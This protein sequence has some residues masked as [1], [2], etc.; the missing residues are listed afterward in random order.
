MSEVEI[1]DFFYVAY[2]RG[3]RTD[4]NICRRKKRKRGRRG[5]KPQKCVGGG[6]EEPG[7]ERKKSGKRRQP[8]IRT[9]SINQSKKSKCCLNY[10]LI[11]IEENSR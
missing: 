8:A 11:P 7:A 6:K 2:Y 5:I 9:F 1:K 4:Q 3:E 10:D